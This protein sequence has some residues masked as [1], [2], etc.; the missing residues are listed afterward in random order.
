MEHLK[1]KGHECI[2]FGLSDEA[3]KCDYPVPGLAVAEAINAL[4]YVLRVIQLRWRQ[5]I[6]KQI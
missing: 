1:E 5:C 2:D 4:R 6:M 3:G